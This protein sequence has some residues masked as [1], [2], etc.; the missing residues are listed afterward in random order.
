[1]SKSTSK[2]AVQ[3]LTLPEI[4][5]FLF[6]FL[7]HFVHEVWQSPYYDFYGMPSLSDKIDYT[8]HCTAGDGL[9]T[10]I[11][12]WAVSW[13]AH[14]RYW[15]LSPTG[16]LALLFTGFGWL[17]TFITEIYRVNIA[18]LYGVPVLTVPG[19]GISP[20]ALLQWILLPPLVLYLA[21]RHMLSYKD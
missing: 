19:V 14:S 2:W 12:G 3:I 15:L 13:L 8:T 7:L 9:I 20:F 4:N 17:I 18:R 1:M 16:K 11:S 21:Q 5:L 10:L 6:A